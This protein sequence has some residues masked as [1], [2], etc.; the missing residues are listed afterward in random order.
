MEK[1]LSKARGRTHG[2]ALLSL[3]LP[4]AIALGRER[5]ATASRDQD[6]AKRIEGRQML[7]AARSLLCDFFF[8]FFAFTSPEQLWGAQADFQSGHAAE[9]FSHG[10]GFEKK[11]N[12]HSKT[13]QISLAPQS[14]LSSHACSTP[15]LDKILPTTT[16]ATGAAFSVSV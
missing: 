13:Q 8:F 4:R 9:L 16:P 3:V 15:A 11:Q 1:D 14:P 6:C 2:P 7:G 12:H 10:F 5:R